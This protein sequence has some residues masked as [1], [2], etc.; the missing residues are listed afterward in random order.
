MAEREG[1]RVVLRGPNDGDAINLPMDGLQARII[2]KAS[3]SETSRHWALGEAWQDAGFE[4]PP[5]THDEAEAFYVLEGEYTFYADT[6]PQRES[7]QAPSSSS[8]QARFIGSAPAHKVADFFVFGRLRSK[9][10]SR[11]SRLKRGPGGSLE[12]RA[13]R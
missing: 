2:R 6:D 5:H 8:R 13:V 10:H 1:P 9:P 7:G 3:R 11:Q 4:N 12:M